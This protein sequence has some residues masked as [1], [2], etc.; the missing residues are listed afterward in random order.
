VGGRSVSD[1]E[2]II[3][4]E[5]RSV[6]R[7]PGFDLEDVEQEMRL[8]VHRK[9]IPQVND[10]RKVRK[11]Q[12]TGRTYVTAAVRRALMN[13]RR[14]ALV[15]ARQ[16]YYPRGQ[17][18]SVVS[19]ELPVF[20]KHETDQTIGSRAESEF[21][22]PERTAETMELMHH[23]DD[24][25]STDDQERLFRVFVQCVGSRGDRIAAEK[26]RRRAE[27]ILT[28]AINHV[29]IIPKREDST[30]TEKLPACHAEGAEPLGYETEDLEE[31]VSCQ[32]CS[33]KFT[34]L[35]KA[36][37]LK[38]I[39]AELSLDPEVEAV[40]NKQHL[41]LDQATARVLKRQELNKRKADI[42]EDLKYDNVPK[43]GKASTQ[44][45]EDKGDQE[46]KS[47][48]TT[49][50][51]P[52]AKA[53]PP[54]KK[55]PTKA[56]K[57][58]PKKAAAKAAAPKA[59]A[60]KA[61]PKKAAAKKAAPAKAKSKAK[62]APKKAAQLERATAQ[63]R[64]N[65]KAAAKS[66]ANGKPRS[67]GARKPA[68]WKVDK[69]TGRLILGHGTEAQR[70]VGAPKALNTEQM[71][72][73]IERLVNAGNLGLDFD[74][75]PGMVLTCVR[76]NGDK[77]VIKIAKDGFV[78][79]GETFPSLTAACTWSVKRNTAGP[80]MFNFGAKTGL[81]IKGKGVPKGGEFTT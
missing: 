38:L 37:K 68:P 44:Q 72:N 34:C 47:K 29:Q 52:K 15:K 16:P 2:G 49:A 58:A 74:L 32:N 56:K 57:A 23:L 9:C 20:N 61:A 31:Q 77:I 51:A 41:T 33:S 40:Q 17:Y 66:K 3:K 79:D 46:M 7:I 53:A 25:L 65:A 11:F 50:K 60:K 59:A 18:G 14:D 78:W 1:Y 12:N 26:V 13:L 21:P 76:R 24:Q 42:P 45:E 27:A 30:M 67:N 43:S 62:A 10:P 35:P 54:P 70:E 6:L 71:A 19:I 73:A 48:T 64:K 80:D 75:K 28:T 36:I 81:K 63:E 69:K 4:K 55:A 5:V 39:D 8:M 22:S